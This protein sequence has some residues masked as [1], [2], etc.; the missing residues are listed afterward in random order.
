TPEDGVRTRGASRN[1]AAL[2]GGFADH[3]PHWDQL[4][5]S[6][7]LMLADK[8]IFKE[9][10]RQPMRYRPDKHATRF[11][12]RLKPRRQVR[13]VANDSLLARD[14]CSPGSNQPGRDANAGLQRFP[15]GAFQTPDGSGNFQSGADRTFGRVFLRGRKAKKCYDAVAQVLR[16][17]AVVSADDRGANLAVFLQQMV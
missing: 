1:E 9:S 11:G 12:E 4:A 8:P 13:R 14:A 15:I 5:I 7:D 10:L 17:M 3:L 6:L 2:D 16:D